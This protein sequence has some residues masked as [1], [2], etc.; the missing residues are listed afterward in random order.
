MRIPIRPF[1]NSILL[2][3]TNSLFQGPKILLDQILSFEQKVPEL[4]FR[5]FIYQRIR[6]RPKQSLDPGS[7]LKITGSGHSI[8]PGPLLTKDISY[9]LWKIWFCT[10]GLIMH[11]FL[12]IEITSLLKKKKKMYTSQF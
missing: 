8:M 1:Q 9:R 11:I 2:I 12:V 3:I 10:F 7:R 4:R 6:I 5:L